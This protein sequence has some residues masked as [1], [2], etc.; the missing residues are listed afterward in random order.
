M[1][2]KMKI[3]VEGLTMEQHSDLC[4]LLRKWIREDNRILVERSRG[5]VIEYT[6]A[7]R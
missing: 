2:N 7:S 6:V 3:V 4:S 5:G 1:S